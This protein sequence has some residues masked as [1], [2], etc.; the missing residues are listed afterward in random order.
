[1]KRKITFLIAALCA[2]MMVTQSYTAVGQTKTDPTYKLTAVTSVSAGN[3][4]VFAQ[5][6]YVFNNTTK[7]SALQTTSSYSTTGLSGTESYVWT[8]ESATGGFLMRNVNLANNYYLN[9]SSGA[10]VSFSSS[11][12]T[13]RFTFTNGVALIDNPSNDNR[14][15]GNNGSN[16]FKAYA[17]SNYNSYA[18][19]ITVY[20]LEEESDDP[21]VTVT[22]SLS[23]FTYV[24]GAGPSEAQSFKVSG[25]NLGNN[26]ITVSLGNNSNYEMSEQNGNNWSTI[27]NGTKTLSPNN[28]GTVGETTLYVRLKSGLTGNNISGTITVSTTAQGVD[29]Q[30]INLTGS[31]T[32]TYT[33]TYSATNGNISGVYSGSSTVVTSGAAMVES[34]TVT[35]TAQPANGYKFTSWSVAGTG[36]TL[37]STSTN[38]TTFT[39]GTANST[40]TATFTART[41]ATVTLHDGLNGET[42]TVVNTYTDATL[43][44]VIEGHDIASVNGWTALGWVKSYTSGTPT[45]I[46][47][48]EAVGSTTNLYAVYSKGSNIFTLINDTDDLDLNGNYMIGYGSKIMKNVKSTNYMGY[49]TSNTISDGAFEYVDGR[50]FILGGTSGAYTFY[51][52]S[53]YLSATNGEQ[54]L[55]LTSG[56]STDY[57]KWSIS[58]SGDYAMISNNGNSSNKN[59]SFYSK[60]DYFNCY[61][62]DGAVVNLYKQ[63]SSVNYSTTPSAEKCHVTYNANGATSGDVPTDSGEYDPND[64][65]TV[66]GNTGPLVKTGYT[67]SGWCLNE[68]GTGTVYGPTPFTTTY[69]IQANT[70]FYAKWVVNTHTV[71]L[72]DNDAYGEY[73]MN[74]SN[75]I[76]Y[77]T[78]VTLTYTKASGYENYKA[79]WSVNGTPIAG[80]KFNMPDADVTVTVSVEE[81]TQASYIFN[82][83][84]GLEDLG[85]SK[86][87]SGAGTNL[88]NTTYSVG[89]VDMTCTDGSTATRVWNSNGTLTLRVYSGGTL[90]FEV[91]STPIAYVITKV[92]F[93]GTVNLTYG[94]NPATAVSNKTWTGQTNSITFT[95]A[96]DQSQITT[97]TVTYARLR[98]LSFW[99]NGTEAPALEKGV[100][101]GA[102]I[103]TLPTTP[104][105]IPS[106]YT[107]DG[108]MDLT[109]SDNYYGTSAPTMVTTNTIV[110]DDMLLA[111]VFHETSTSSN[112]TTLFVEFDDD[113]LD[114]DDLYGV[115]Q[116]NG[117]VVASSFE[118]H[119]QLVIKNGGILEM[120]AAQSLTN[121]TAANL[122]IEDGGQLIVNNA[123]VQATFQK[124]IEDATAKD[125]AD[126]WYTISTPTGGINI[127]SVTNL[128]NNAGGDLQYNLFRYDEPS[129]IWEAYNTTNHADFTTLEK[130]RGYLYRNNGQDLE[131]PGEVNVGNV[132]VHLTNTEASAAL[133][134]FNLIGN[135][136]GHNIYKGVGAAI[137]E[138]KLN[139]G[140]YYLTDKGAWQTGTHETPITP[141]MGI[142]VQLNN[143]YEELDLTITD[144][145]TTASAERYANDNLMF[146]V[147]N[148]D[149]EDVTYAMFHK[150]YGLNKINHRNADIPMLYINHDNDDYAIAMLSD[151]TKA[152]NLCFKAKTTGQYK[153]TYKAEGEFSYLHVIDRL[154]G[155]D[156]DMLLEGEYNFIG[157]PHDNAN[158]FIVSLGYLPDY[159]EGNND[160]FAFQNGSDILVS[161]QGELQ[162]FDV[163]GR[164]IKNMNINGAE[165]IN[166]QSQGVYILRLVGT[167]VK[168]QKIVV[169]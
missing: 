81:M 157:T 120:D 126:H 14:F 38:P 118:N 90:T 136:Y 6:G 1:M 42:T 63:T 82:T 111:A 9:N 78:E 100:A 89:L 77:N 10:G 113:V 169:K 17:T 137:A 3:K 85:I 70:T 134:G 115:N 62:N 142:L 162:I 121:T 92:E 122:I 20:I 65:V 153:L 28:S 156:I 52:G 106:G 131:F 30:T 125:A 119:G 107:F 46:T 72:P 133:R 5:N 60:N 55:G 36:S 25:V 104:S 110:S 13:W 11:S 145:T 45:L 54:Y 67:W 29:D 124:D 129:H 109:N 105:G 58:F 83:D 75:P 56:A 66:K 49:T 140:F 21:T 51:D 88:G 86:P 103:G 99:V 43:A 160:I 143:S 148:K 74:K 39:M 22:A 93:G 33:L 155:N 108:W 95:N 159:G 102:K 130:G 117:Y 18:H 71:T 166:V 48:S 168:T 12:T 123:G 76:A 35:L 68:A 79:T 34:T 19:D 146:T 141:K 94:S 4:Y 50:V 127:T 144:K 132:T 16:A 59:I 96:S 167:E 40:V 101:N 44:E 151:D 165:T 69:S 98:T 7:S 84:D 53:T 73:S 47:I 128:V 97:I 91:P 114:V 24:Q 152:F 158:R 164:M 139:N 27:A 138:A 8:L 135:P 64:D 31:V 23:S 37:S 15:L 163:T 112:Y 116:I 80:N 149:Y 57:Q 26:N 154:T 61:T 161:G 32:P 41:P 87:N 147:S 2:V 150:G